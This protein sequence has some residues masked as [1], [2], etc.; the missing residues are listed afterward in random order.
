ME[1]TLNLEPSAFEAA[2]QVALREKITLDEAVSKLILQTVTLQDEAAAGFAQLDR[3]E[4]M[5]LDKET[6]FR[7]ITGKNPLA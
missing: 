7:Q 6:F 2:R 3:G 4:C 1:T 5:E